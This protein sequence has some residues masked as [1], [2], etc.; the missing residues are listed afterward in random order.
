[1]S[2][3]E[4]TIE[5]DEGEEHTV[6]VPVKWEIC[7]QCQG[8]G[9]HSHHMGD[10]TG[11]E[12]AEEDHDFQEDYMNGAYDKTCQCCK[13]TG[14]IQAIDEEGFLQENPDAYHEWVEQEQA[15]HDFRCE[16]EAERRMGA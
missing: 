11:S 8:E 10:W 3:K 9:K 15:D 16:Q 1:M 5:N 6:D 2:T 4:I 12:W 13:G 7:Y 14:K